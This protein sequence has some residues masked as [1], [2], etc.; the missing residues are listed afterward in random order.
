MSAARLVLP[1]SGPVTLRAADFVARGGQGAV[2][3]RGDV[4]YKVFD[5]PAACP[6]A[7]KVAELA[8]VTDPSVVK[9]EQLLLR[10]D[11]VPVGYTMRYVPDAWPLCRLF[12]R[13]FR[14]QHGVRMATRVRLVGRMA[15]TVAA[16]HAAGVVVVDL[17]EMNALVGPAFDTVWFIDADSYQTPSYPATALADHVR[18]R[19]AEPGV[20]DAA[21]DWFAF[22]VVSFQLL[23]GAHPFRGTH[24]TVKGLDARM[25]ANLSAFDPAVTLPPCCEPVANIPPRLRAWYE[26]VFELGERTAPP[27]DISVPEPAASALP[28]GEILV[29]LG[30]GRRVQLRRDPELHLF[31]LDAGCP[32]AL[33]TRADAA[34]VHANRL[35]LKARDNLLEV[36]LHDGG[37]RVFATT[38]VAGRVHA[39]ATRLFPGA[40]VQS[41]L[42]ATFVSLFVA[43]GRCPQ[44]R[45]PELDGY[46]VVDA[47][48]DRETLI[49]LAERGGAYHRVTVRF[50]SGFGAH[51]VDVESAVSVR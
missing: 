1:G 42:G 4:A 51:D 38:R 48:L 28:P 15:R 19:H 5:D 24:P 20:F 17:S 32:V 6:S 10:S 11:G 26:A 16:L 47:R 12:T 2:Y 29:T 35:Y 34:V 31:D 37:A 49:V 30:R 14:D 27:L 13:A 39:R 50:A 25:R 36:R 40:A 46:R 41:L 18:D 33:A 45:I 22:A 3:A 21:T 8:A 7:A 9:P 44:V 43:P 23:V